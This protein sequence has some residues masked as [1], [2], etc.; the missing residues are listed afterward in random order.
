MQ[1]PGSGLPLLRG[2]VPEREIQNYQHTGTVPKVG[3]L[4]PNFDAQNVINLTN[5]DICA[6]IVFYNDA[7][8]IVETDNEYARLKKVIEFLSH[9]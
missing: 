6:L 4:P 2:I 8:G 3:D 5:E 7:F 1:V 9:F